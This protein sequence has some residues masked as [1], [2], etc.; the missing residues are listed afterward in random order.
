MRDASDGW[1]T[2]FGA[3]GA[4]L[5]L[6]Y[7]GTTWTRMQSPL[8]TGMSL[9]SLSALASAD[10]RVLGVPA[11]DRRTASVILRYDGHTWTQE[12]IAISNAV[13]T[14]LVMVSPDDGWAVGDYCACGA[15]YEQNL[16]P[17]GVYAA[18]ILRYHDS[19]WQEVTSVRHPIAAPLFSLAMPSASE[20]WAVGF[21]SR[22][23]Q[24]T[25]GAWTEVHSPSHRDGELS[26]PSLVTIAMS[27]PTDGWAGGNSGTLLHYTAGHWAHY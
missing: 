19:A 16:P 5:L 10:V 11:A 14:A 21:N 12:P 3:D 7:D 6:H 2:G 20:G 18:L 26:R 22:I 1:A 27:S 17:Q 13:L 24:Y 15:N 23:V 8:F 4:G 25:D 9:S